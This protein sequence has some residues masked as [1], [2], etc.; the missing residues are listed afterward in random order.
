MLSRAYIC[1]HF[2]FKLICEVS[3]GDIQGWK[4]NGEH[5][6]DLPLMWL[7]NPCILNIDMMKSGGWVF[8]SCTNNF[9]LLENVEICD[10]NS[11]IHDLINICFSNRSN[12]AQ[13]NESLLKIVC[14]S[15]VKMVSGW[16][17]NFM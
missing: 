5:P 3:Y 15:L 10:L 9:N 13:I 14:S 4:K 7:L 17:D 8:V 2:F 12:N 16:D 11:Y 6:H 1:N